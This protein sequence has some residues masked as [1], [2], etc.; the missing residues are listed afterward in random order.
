MERRLREKSQVQATRFGIPVDSFNPGTYWIVCLDSESARPSVQE[1]TIIHSY[2]QYM[3]GH[4]YNETWAAKLRAMPLPAVGRHNTTILRKR[5]R[6][7]WQYRKMSWEHGSLFVPS[8]FEEGYTKT[9]LKD[10][11]DRERS[12]AGRLPEDW[13]AWK[14]AR[15]NLFGQ[16]A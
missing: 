14:A 3:I 11:L 12:I 16:D 5:G 2:Q 1:L 15:P 13:I 10:V 9:G 8:P 6:G 7:E 4:V